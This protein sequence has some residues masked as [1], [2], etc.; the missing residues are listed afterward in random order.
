VNN[1]IFAAVPGP[2]IAPSTFALAGIFKV[3]ITSIAELS[4]YNLLLV[5]AIGYVFSF[6]K[7]FKLSNAAPSYE[8]WLKNMASARNFSLLLLPGRLAPLF[9]LSEPSK[10]TTILY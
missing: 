8:S 10:Q 1:I 7:K 2:I 4:G 5:G 6:V 3:P 9:A